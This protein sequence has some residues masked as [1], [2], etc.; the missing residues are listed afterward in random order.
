MASSS[1][2]PIDLDAE[3]QELDF[4]AQEAAAKAKK[5][6]LE[7]GRAK[8]G[9]LRADYWQWLKPVLWRRAPDQPVQC[10]LECTRGGE[11][12]CG[13]LLS[14]ENASKSARDHDKLTACKGLGGA[15]KDC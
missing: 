1:A 10:M 3:G 5:A 15:V 13:K 9:R 12:V 6:K 11:G 4:A 2:E 7:D 8:Q 14:S